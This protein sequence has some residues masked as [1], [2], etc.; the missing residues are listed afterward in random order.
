MTSSFSAPD[1][2]IWNRLF[3][4]VP[5]EWRTAPP[6]LAMNDCRESLLSGGAE[7]VLDIGCG[8]GRWA[9]HLAKAG[10]EVSGSDFAENG[11]AYAAA[12][13]RDEGVHLRL[14][15]CP[16]TELPFPGEQ[17]DA[18]IAA[19]VLDNV[20]RSEMKT[21]IGHM[22]ASLREEGMAFCLFNPV[23]TRDERTEGGESTNPTSGVTHVVYDDD[24]LRAAFA[25]FTILDFRRYEMG[26]RGLFLQRDDEA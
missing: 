18:V 25:G 4:D 8:V 13:A 15:C 19:L 9:I 20:S 17:F 11:L 21:A 1:R 3:A 7:S 22:R 12:W 10:L 23:G 24:E 14:T 6:S 26:T 16:I 5:P 2:A